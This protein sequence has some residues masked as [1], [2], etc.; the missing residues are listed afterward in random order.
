MNI[1]IYG[2]PQCPYC[3]KAIKLCE[4]KDVEFQYF[5]VGEPTHISK[6]QLIEKIH[7]VSGDPDIV[8][9]TVPQV[10]IADDAG[11]ERYINGGYEGLYEEL[12][13]G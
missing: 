13:K 3:E 8:V 2:R 11:N 12:V 1:T 4:D 9:R 6:E 5:T 7:T 10:F